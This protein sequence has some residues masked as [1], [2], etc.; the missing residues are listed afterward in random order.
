MLLGYTFGRGDGKI[1]DGQ[2]L[3]IPLPDTIIK[4]M[5]GYIIIK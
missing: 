4:L 1:P 2:T 5:E 3:E